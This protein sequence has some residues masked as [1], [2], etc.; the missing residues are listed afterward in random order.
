[1]GFFLLYKSQIFGDQKIGKIG[2]GNDEDLS[3]KSSESW[4]WSQYLREDMK[5]TCCTKIRRQT[6]KK[7]RHQETKKLRN[8]E[9]EKVRNQETKKLID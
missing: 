9:N 8:S 5:W 6:T 2:T 1:M 3:K 7:R 4:K